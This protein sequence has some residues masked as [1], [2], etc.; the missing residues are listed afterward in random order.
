MQN[1]LLLA[2]GMGLGKTAAVLH[3]IYELK[4]ERLLIVA[5]KRVAETVWLQEAQKWGL[6][7][8]ADR[9]VIVKGTPEKRQ[10]ALE[11]IEHPYKI[12]SR[13][14]LV[15]VC[16]NCYELLVID[17]L[18]SFKNVMSVRSQYIRTIQATHKIGLTGTFLANGM[19]DVFGQMAALGIY[20]CSTKTSRGGRYSWCPEFNSWRELYFRDVLKGSGLNFQ[21]WQPLV[22]IDDILADCRQNIF[23]LDSA[24]WLE[25]PAV[26]YE[27]H[28]IEMTERE[29]N[30]YTRLSA[31]LSVELNGEVLTVDEQS[32]F[33]K[34]QTLCNGFIYDENGDVH[35]GNDST[36]LEAVADFC[37]RCAAENERVLLF[38]AFREE[39]VWL[40]E[41]LK[42]R[43]LLY[44]SP[45]DKDFI[46]KWNNADIDVLIAHPAS[47][48]HGLNLQAGGR[49]CVWSSITYNYEYW[50]QA[51]ARLARQGQ[52]KGV[53]IHVFATK[54]T[55]ESKQYT[56]VTNK[57]KAD[58]EF[59]LK[60]KHGLQ[61]NI[62]NNN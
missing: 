42:A 6:D 15:S 36:K 10:K 55:V 57:A 13:D 45:A 49:I 11:D 32:K 7:Y 27:R 43:G 24:D 26:S 19:I 38:Y 37:E 54:D 9:M 2:V 23:T 35:R 14:N 58:K 59:V 20:T 8:V 39:A 44:C 33:T 28:D 30:E 17:E 50:A 16:Y 52:S 25:I 34:L 5:P 4:P 48:G 46:Q 60:T 1:K 53:Q 18:T 22:P 12:I 31:T 56:A 41:K 61:G 62:F 51:N 21:K 47:S 3:Y 40:A 29:Q